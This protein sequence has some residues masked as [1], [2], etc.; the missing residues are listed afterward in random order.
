MCVHRRNTGK[1]PRG[2]PTGGSAQD[3]GLGEVTRMNTAAQSDASP[4]GSARRGSRPGSAGPGRFACVVR[5]VAVAA[6]HRP[7]PA[8]LRGQE[9]RP[10]H[11]TGLAPATCH[12]QTSWFCLG[13]SPSDQV[14]TPKQA[15]AAARP[16]ACAAQCPRGQLGRG[17]PRAGV[18]AAVW[19]VGG[20]GSPRAGVRAPEGITPS[21]WLMQDHGVARPGHQRPRGSRGP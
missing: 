21:A 1:G 3:G 8:G 18:R 11:A 5:D 20:G 12:A 10:R 4:A 6:G 9:G 17:S 14:V 7:E 13:I 16:C 15:E 2:L 19:G